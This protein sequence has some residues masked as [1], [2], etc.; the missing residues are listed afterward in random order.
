MGIPTTHLQFIRLS[1]REARRNAEGQYSVLTYTLERESYH[2]SN[3]PS[4]SV[5]ESER[6][7][8]TSRMLGFVLCS[9]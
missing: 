3:R 2:A 9:G 8:D 6:E 7:L 1:V 5:R 4:V